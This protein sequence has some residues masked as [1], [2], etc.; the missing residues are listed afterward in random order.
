MATATLNGKIYADMIKG[1]AAMLNLNRTIVNDLN[2]FPIPDG[3]TGDNMFMTIESG[4]DSIGGNESDDLGKTAKV[5]ATGMLSGARGNSGAILSQIFAGI[6]K[7]F[8]GVSDADISAV[9]HAFECGVRQAYKAVKEPVEGTILT[10]FREAVSYA[11]EKAN[12][13][14]SLEDFFDDL[15]TELY[16]SLKRTPDLLAVLKEA[17][18]VDSGGAGFVYIAEGMKK[19]LIGDIPAYEKEPHQGNGS[20]QI[21]ISTF[22]EDSEL[23]FGYCTEF[24]LRLQ[25]K[26]CDVENFDLKVI[27][28][29]LDSVGDSVVA[30]M[31]GSIVKAHVHTFK[32]GEVLNYCQQFGEFLTLK[33]ENMTL[34][35]N[36]TTIQNKFEQKEASNG[37]FEMKTKPRKR[38]GL[39]S[40]AA[41][42]GVKNLFI[43]SGC[44]V[45]VDGGQS[46]NPSVG[47]F[48]KA[49][50][51]INAETI[52]VFPNNSNIIM[53][54]NQA[55]ELCETAKV[56]VLPTKNIGSGYAAISMFDPSGEEDEV[57]SALQESADASLT[58]MVSR[59]VRDTDKDGVSVLKDSFIGFVGSTIYS[60]AAER[61]EA[62]MQLF[63][64][65]D[66]SDYGLLMVLRGEGASEDELADITGKIAEKYHSLEVIPYEGGQPVFDYIFILL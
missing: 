17:G 8:E 49:F 62:A 63:E 9:C 27:S 30:F 51:E 26:K 20:H 58:A 53:T 47:D 45:V 60:S 4:V 31:D 41:G 12:D 55:A 11:N 22:T 13:T 40:C 28:D 34:Q 21:D 18:V 3:D 29:Y 14:T 15:I 46:M 57:L 6:S 33:I 19:A 42:E 1:G 59:A 35:H 50:A 64:K 7:G 39:V 61:N 16:A 56:T 37:D 25:H 24:L 52:F 66:I 5:I 54:A 38:Y 23:K 32:P 10:V 43:E 2:V 65:L 44:D 48:L 36:E